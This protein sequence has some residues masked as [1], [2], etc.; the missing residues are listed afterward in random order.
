MSDDVVY[1]A[2]SNPDVQVESGVDMLAC[3]RCRN[4]TYRLEC[5]ED[6]CG[7]SVH[8]AACGARIG[9]MGWVPEDDSEGQA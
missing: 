2:Y 5:Y 3:R 1:L 6:D 8:C 9:K 7:A 4:K